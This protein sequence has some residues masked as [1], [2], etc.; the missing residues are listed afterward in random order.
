MSRAPMLPPAHSCYPQAMKCIVKSNFKRIKQQ[1][2]CCSPIWEPAHMGSGT[3]QRG[4]QPTCPRHVFPGAQG[5]FPGR[6]P[7]S[8]RYHDH[9]SR[10]RAVVV[11]DHTLNALPPRQPLTFAG[12]IS[13]SPLRREVAT[14][15]NCKSN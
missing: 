15:N 4:H 8:I 12:S 7:A 5:F 11:P 6:S 10:Q 14:Q 13:A 1:D 3:S 9:R 2:S